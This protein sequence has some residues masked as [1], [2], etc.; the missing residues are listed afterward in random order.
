MNADTRPKRLLVSCVGIGSVTSEDRN[1]FPFS[2]WKC[3]RCT[4]ASAHPPPF[5]FAV[6]VGAGR[7]TSRDPPAL[8]EFWHS[9]STAEESPL[10]CFVVTAPSG[11]S[12]VDVRTSPPWL[13]FT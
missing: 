8:L 7:V 11:P 1:S 2:L 3:D 5:G 13:H 12:T 6:I 9:T 4:P 10:P